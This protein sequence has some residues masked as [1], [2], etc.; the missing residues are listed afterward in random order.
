MMRN[1][2]AAQGGILSS[3]RWI[4][5]LGEQGFVVI[6]VLWLLFL[7]FTTR[8]FATL[9]N[10]S[11]VLR[12]AA[13][14]AIVAIGEH[15]IV[16]LGTMDVSLPSILTVGGVFTGALMVNA[17]VPALPAALC[18]LALGGLLG[19]ANGAIVTRL[20]I[21]PIITPLGMM[22]ILSGIAFVYTKGRTVYGD[23]LAPIDFLA[24]GKLLG[25][26]APILIMFVLYVIFHLVLRYTRFGARVFAAGNNEK[27]SWL[28]GIKTS[29]VKQNVFMLAGVLAA[30]AGFMQ[31]ARQGSAS[32][33]MGDDFLFPVLTAVVLGGTSLSGGKGKIFNTLIAS[34]F[35]MTIKNGMILLDLSI[36]IQKIIQG[37][38]LIL[39]LSLDR[40]HTAKGA[41]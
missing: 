9:D 8:S 20:K 31:V 26:S 7:T 22:Y 16:L 29:R 30:F 14:I 3:R 37:A 27:A 12:Q 33:S 5:I 10:V 35:L 34:I 32:A 13:I 18:V 41:S 28:A 40:L 36:Y 21:N 6:F 24:R 25:I 17:H 11:T 39:A 1:T 19:L 38:I 15:F 4:N 23:A 2:Q